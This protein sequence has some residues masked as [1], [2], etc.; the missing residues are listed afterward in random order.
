MNTKPVGLVVALI[1]VR[2]S[3]R[4]VRRRTWPQ[5][6]GPQR[7]GVSTE[8]GLLK[9]WPA[10]GPTLAWQVND[11]GDGYSSVAV[12]GD[13]LYTLGNLGLDNEFVRA[14]SVQDGKT[15]RTTRLGNVGNPDRI[16]QLPEGE[17]DA[18]DRGGTPD[19]VPRAPDGD[20]ACL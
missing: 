9:Q 1:V 3:L 15:L 2:G 8:T 5:W 18:D 16:A 12:V 11:I 20:L 7:H 14:M 17:I 13:R 6:R 4:H 19:Y 10:A